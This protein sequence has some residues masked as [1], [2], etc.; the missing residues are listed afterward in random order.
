MRRSQISWSDSE[1]TSGS[2]VVV[3]LSFQ[4]SAFMKFFVASVTLNS[5]RSH[6][7]QSDVVCVALLQSMPSHHSVI[8]YS[9][10]DAHF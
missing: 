8:D 2:S 5:A 9:L 4:E 1:D 6:M 7:A 3:L 10:N